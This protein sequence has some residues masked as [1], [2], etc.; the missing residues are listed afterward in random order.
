MKRREFC[1]MSLMG[2]AAAALPL[3][4]LVAGANDTAQ[5]IVTD[6]RAVKLSGAETT[7]ER[8]A[9]QDLRASLRGSLI[10][11]GESG[12]D[13]ARRVWNGM[14]DKHPAL[15]ARCADVVD[16]VRAVTFAREREL[17]LAVRGGGHSFP[18]YSTCDGGMVIDLSGMTR[19]TVDARNQT[20]HVS[21]GA[22]VA[23][24]DGPAQQQGLATTLG[25][26]SNTGVGG[27]TLGGG[28]GWLSRRFGL[29]CDNLLGAELVTADGKLRRVSAKDEPD[30]FWAIRGGGGNFGVATSFDYRL[31]PLNPTVLAGHVSYPTAQIKD[32]IGFYADFLAKAPRELSVDLSLGPGADDQPGA[33]IHVL[34]T[35]NHATGEKLLAALQRFGKPVKDTIAAQTYLT[36]Q[37]QFD[38]PPIDPTMNY[39]KGGFVRAVSPELIDVLVRDYRTDKRNSAYF[40]NANGAVADTAPT[41]TAFTHRNAMANLMLGGSWEDP[42]FN[43]QG[44]AEVRANWAKVERFTDGY[45]VNLNDA[46]AKGADRNYGTNFDR[47]SAL[48]KRYDPMN[49]FR[50]NSNINV[51]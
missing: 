2:G 15:I 20:A 39:I 31:H 47:L 1:G 6:L 19:V 8:A 9:L 48:K 41:A 46:D 44:R 10:V 30:L 37:S 33:S 42:A 3:G 29:A 27:L 7:I 13:A 12:Y 32:A 4:R 22:W 51:A 50:L 25:Q 21:G 16:V 43:E 49:L 23:H 38:G 24:V 17:L 34:Y 45:Y 11:S 14:I 5:P 26:I 40:Q 35:G 28:F 36:V 18:G